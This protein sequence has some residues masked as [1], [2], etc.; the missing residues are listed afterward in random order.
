MMQREVA[1]GH[2]A[3]GRGLDPDQTI[4]AIKAT[5]RMLNIIESDGIIKNLDISNTKSDALDL[6]FSK[7][8]IFSSNF[9][10][11]GSSF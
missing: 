2:M 11:I 8:D 1:M 10:N 7:V 6:D 4:A 9:K 3:T 5:V